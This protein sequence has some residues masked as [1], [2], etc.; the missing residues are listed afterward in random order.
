V[1]SAQ[2]HT[3][4]SFVASKELILPL[5]KHHVTQRARSQ[6]RGAFHEGLSNQALSLHNELEAT[7]KAWSKVSKGL[8]FPVHDEFKKLP[9]PKLFSGSA[10][11]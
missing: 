1:A 3:T 11:S 10:G 4:V 7:A 5:T 2:A 6:A 8:K 9:L